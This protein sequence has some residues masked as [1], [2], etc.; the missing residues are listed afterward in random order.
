MQNLGDLIRDIA[1]D[2]NSRLFGTPC[3]VV[4]YD[5]SDQTIL[6]EPI[7]G[8]A[9]FTAKLQAE[10]KPG[11]LYIPVIGSVVMVEQT[12]PDSGYVSMWGEIEEIVFIGGDNKGLVKVTEL[13][14]KL[15]ALENKVNVIINTFNTHV[16]SGVTTGGGS[17][18]ISPTPVN[19]TLQPTQIND[20]ENPKITH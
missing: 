18:A 11:L 10:P 17:S 20:L 6:C 2:D 8:T 4:S 13:V 3:T 12:S 14:D 5:D 1:K 7:D 16:H 19:G 9:E 15:N